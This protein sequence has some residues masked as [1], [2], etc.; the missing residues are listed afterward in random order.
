MGN[1]LTR[2]PYVV[3]SAA[4][5]WD[6]T[7]ATGAGKYVQLIQWMDNAADIANNNTLVLTIDGQVLTGKIA[8]TTDTINNLV[9]WEINFPVPMFIQKFIVTTIDKGELVIWFR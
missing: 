2:S 4:T 6:G 8:M 1:E 5:I 3:E 7:T 9:V